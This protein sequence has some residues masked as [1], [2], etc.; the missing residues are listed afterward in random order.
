MPPRL[1]FPVRPATDRLNS[2]AALA[3]LSDNGTQG[4]RTAEDGVFSGL[5]NLHELEPG[6]TMFYV[7]GEAT[8]PAQETADF[9]SAPAE[10]EF[11]RL[12]ECQGMNLGLSFLFSRDT[13]PSGVGPLAVQLFP[14]VPFLNVGF[15][16]QLDPSRLHAS[17]DPSGIDRL[18]SV[19]WGSQ[20][21]II[22]GALDSESAPAED[23]DPDPGQDNPIKRIVD[24]L[25]R[26]GKDNC[27]DANDAEDL[28]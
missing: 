8:G 2:E 23:V 3:T 4:D 16:E 5:I 7:R 28:R 10:L 22:V 27:I 13:T 12:T 6:Q 14:S 11:F 24:A 18:L 15:F 20:D 19:F 1:G 21:V 25:Q 17:C 26:I 9:G